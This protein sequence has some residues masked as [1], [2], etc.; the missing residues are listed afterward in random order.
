MILGGVLECIGCS[1]HFPRRPNAL[2]DAIQCNDKGAVGNG[3]GQVVI[4]EKATG[5]QDSRK[6]KAKGLVLD[7]N[8]FDAIVFAQV[9]PV[10][11]VFEFER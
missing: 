1:F 5:S 3:K 4:A 7:V 2:L 6:F 11:V 10:I 8:G 9:K